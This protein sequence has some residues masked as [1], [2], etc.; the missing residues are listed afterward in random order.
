MATLPFKVCC[1]QSA[2]EADMA[3]AAGALALGL[4]S[5]MPSGPGPVSD[6]TIAAIAE[7]SRE[8][9]GDAVWTVLLTS[10]T[11]GEA[12]AAHVAETQVNTVQ[13]VDRPAPGA[14]ETLRRAHP[15]LRVMQV[16]HVQDDTAIEEARRAA[17]RV[18]VILLDSGKPNAPVRTLG[19]TG[20]VHDWSISKRIVD[21][22]ERPV[23]LAGGL[24]PD[25]A[26][27][28]IAAARPFGLDVCSGLRDPSAGYALRRDKLNAFAAA[29]S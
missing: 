27:M 10:R 11:D 20:E 6:E 24:N 1:I 9:Y 17:R 2:H 28:A 21:A 13:I 18:D 4:V 16:V 12:I 22:V 5:R 26:R 25:N 23:F 29:L 19:G 8:R 14:Y 3:V 15:A 7:R